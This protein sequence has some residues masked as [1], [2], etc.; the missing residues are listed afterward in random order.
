[1]CKFMFFIVYKNYTLIKQQRKTEIKIKMF[2]CFLRHISLVRLA[3]CT[4]APSVLVSS[5]RYQHVNAN[6]LNLST[7]RLGSVRCTKLQFSRVA[8][9]C[10]RSKKI[11]LCPGSN[12]YFS[13]LQFYG[14]RPDCLD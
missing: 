12:T 1:M 5:Y 11:K 14:T 9:N 7:S 10:I 6:I 8:I 2:F 13:K 3:R 4:S